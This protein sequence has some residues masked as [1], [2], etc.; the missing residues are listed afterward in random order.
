MLKI[1]PLKNSLGTTPHL[2]ISAISM[3][4][5][6]SCTTDQDEVINSNEFSSSAEKGLSS[7]SQMITI[8]DVSADSEESG[9]EAE[10]TIDDSFST[11][12]RAEGTAIN[13]IADLGA[14]F[15]VDYIGLSHYAGTSREYS[16][17]VWTKESSSASWE[18]NEKFTTAGESSS[19]MYYDL[20]DVKAQFVR[21]KCN[22][23]NVNDYNEIK[24]FEVY[25][26]PASGSGSFNFDKWYLSVPVDNGAG[27]ATS[28]SYTSDVDG[29]DV[30]SDEERYF[31]RNSDGSF[32]MFAEYTGFTTSGTY[33]LE[34]SS[35]YCRT[36][37][38]ERWEGGTT[39]SN[40]SL[41]S[42]THILN[43]T[44]NVDYC[45]GGKTYVAQMH[46]AETDGE[47]GAPA[48]I[49][50]LWEEGTLYIEY[51]TAEG[52][53][54]E[55]EWK[56]TNDEMIEVD[57]V[58][59]SIF[60]V[61]LK[62]DD[63]KFYYA[64]TCEDKGI[65]IGYTYVYDYDKYGYEYDNYFKTGNYFRSNSSYSDSSVVNLYNLTTS[66]N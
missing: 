11:R 32:R 18:R 5:L 23:N 30:D 27:K 1:T 12:W 3:A 63:G 2:L 36:E 45:D 35:K 44:V 29:Y 55:G 28:I 24:K 60:T 37:L 48:T 14:A 49:K 17:E 9:Y 20:T 57:Y 39:N 65:D 66:H 25:G 52:I 50:F 21:V 26:D 41:N 38:R 22:G 61:S 56:S 54:D 10:N 46:G 19:V 31:K 6:F 59:N 62:I 53:N 43:T 51:Y 64:L 33:S 13:L 8:K 40:W 47:V 42:G 15:D 34:T 16:F 58:G 7:S 4:L